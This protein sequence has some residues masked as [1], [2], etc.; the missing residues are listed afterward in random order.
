MSLFGKA[1]LMEAQKSFSGGMLP[2]SRLL[3]RILM[4]VGGFLIFLPGVLS[5]FVGVLL[6]LPGFRHLAVIFVRFYLAKSIARG[7]FRFVNM[8]SRG[9]SFRGGSASSNHFEDSKVERDARVID[10][11]AIESTKNKTE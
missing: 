11:E 10:I 3:H 8:G 4:F 9:F 2:D 7:S 5:D 1:L 6:I